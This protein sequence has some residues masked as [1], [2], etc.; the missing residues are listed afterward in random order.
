MRTDVHS[1]YEKIMRTDV[2]S[3]YEKIM[4]TDDGTYVRRFAKPFKNS[5]LDIPEENR[6]GEKVV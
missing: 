4:R 1:N 5:A 2:H 6:E 3:N